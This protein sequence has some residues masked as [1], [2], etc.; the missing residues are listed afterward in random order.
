MAEK[1]S[2]IG[3]KITIILLS[4]IIIYFVFDKIHTIKQKDSMIVEIET[5][6]MQKDSLNDEL[7]DLFLVY[8]GLQTNNAQINDSLAVQQ[9]RIQ[10]L[11]TELSNLKASDYARIKQLKDEVETLK[12]IMKSY[13][14]QIDSLYQ[15]NQI[16]VAKNTQIQQQYDN[17]VQQTQ[18]LSTQND[19]LQQTI[20][21]AKELTAYSLNLTALNQRGKTTERS[22]K[23]EKFQVCFILSENKVITTGRK[24]VYLRI[25][26]PDGEVLRN[27][28]SG[29]FNYQGQNIAY[30]SVKEI[31]YDGNSQNLCV[32]YTVDVSDLP[33]GNY[34]VFIFSEGKEIGDAS[35]NLN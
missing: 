34:T 31:E 4:F 33:S 28:N 32:Y 30:S 13:V 20:Q 14:H 21:V 23:V 15:A 5:Q 26:K 18:N 27:N 7:E 11:M 2:N 19:S 24:Y 8:E 22:N 6:T 29:F 9:Q 35:I 16:L 1:N 3:Y 17:Q 10:D 12:T 25:T